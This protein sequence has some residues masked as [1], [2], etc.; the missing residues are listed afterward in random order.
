MNSY[1]NNTNTTTGAAID[2]SVSFDFRPS[3]PISV[4][5]VEI[6]EQL[7]GGILIDPDILP[8]ALDLPVAAFSISNHRVIFKT[9]LDVHRAGRKP[10]LYTVALF[11]EKAGTLREA[12]GRSKLA[13]LVDRTLHSGYVRQHADLIKENYQERRLRDKLARLAEFS[14]EGDFNSALQQLEDHLAQIKRDRHQSSDERLKLELQALLQESDPIKKARRKAEICSFYRLGKAA[15]DD[16]LKYLEGQTRTAQSRGFGLNEL[17]DLTQTSIDYLIPGMLPVGETVLL[18]AEPKTGKSLLAYD[19]AFAV[20]TGEDTFLGETT[21]RGRVLIVQCDESIGTAKGRLIKRGFRHEDA[22]NVRVMVSFSITQLADLE[23]ELEE[24]RPSLVVIDNLRRIS[25]NL[26][27][28]ENSSEFSNSVYKLKELL[29][30]YG[31]AGILIHHTNKDRDALGVS[32]VRGSSAIAGAVW[33][34][35]QLDHIPKPDPN[36]KKRLIVDPKDPN[37]IFSILARDVE[38]QRLKIEL[39][40]EVSH[41]LNRGEEGVTEEEMQE[42]S[43]RSSRILELL[44]PIAPL[45]MEARELNEA[46]GLG[47]GIYSAL[48]RL[49]GKRI[50][51][52]RPSTTDRRQTVYFLLNVE[53][54]DTPPPLPSLPNEIEYSESHTSSE[55]Q[56]SISNRSQIDLNRSQGGA[57]SEG[58]LTSNADTASHSEIDL[59]F[60]LKGGEREVSE[61]STGIAPN[62]APQQLPPP[63]SVEPLKVSDR[64]RIN[65]PG[66]KRHDK[67]ATIKRLKKEGKVHLADLAVDGEGFRY[68][69]AQLGWLELV[70]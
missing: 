51:G 62:T 65:C 54:G 58:D 24:F 70:P 14:T 19:A 49:V 33:G 66:S 11:L 23:K 34:V 47:R 16:L 59:K 40:P 29:T 42:Q 55:S 43:D 3:N 28:S 20:A 1:F 35:W 12:G 27:L 53:Q 4:L 44:K 21:G 67:T 37:R 2:T 9:I 6:E 69:E 5:P 25:A 63:S 17:F 48:N 32:R 57:E 38:G 7:L 64:V 22:P 39:D 31:A 15:V 46:L 41:W 36:N 30:R 52:S 68:W 50:I 18:A 56:R 45:G 26:E 10:D 13:S 61:S 8:N 60:D